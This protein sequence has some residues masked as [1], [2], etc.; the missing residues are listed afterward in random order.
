[1]SDNSETCR[2]IQV[3]VIKTNAF[4]NRLGLKDSFG[5]DYIINYSLDQFLILTHLYGEN[6]FLFYIIKSLN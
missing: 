6:I 1:M 2:D 3:Q 5:M 4:N